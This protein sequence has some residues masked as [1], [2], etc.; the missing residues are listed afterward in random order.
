MVD[1]SNIK[2][3]IKIR[4][5]NHVESASPAHCVRSYTILTPQVISV[6]DNDDAQV[7]KFKKIMGE[8]TTQ[9]QAF[10]PV[11]KLVEKV[12]FG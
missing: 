3:R 2:M 12:F 8:D 6:G 5:M 7:C 9:E 1:K 4:K 10:N 11:R